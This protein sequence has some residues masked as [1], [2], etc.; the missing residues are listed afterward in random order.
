MPGD[1][2]PDT[3][4]DPHLSVQDKAGEKGRN[5]LILITLR[6]GTALLKMRIPPVFPS[7]S[8]TLIWA[9]KQNVGERAACTNPAGPVWNPSAIQSNGPPSPL[10]A[11]AVTEPE[12]VFLLGLGT[13]CSPRQ[14]AAS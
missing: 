3:L 7:P 2:L 5:S 10:V 12:P 1:L 4:V 11:V 8:L 6:R 9:A 13:L 14:P